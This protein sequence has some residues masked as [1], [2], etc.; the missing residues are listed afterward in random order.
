M[1]FLHKLNNKKA[2]KVKACAIESR[3]IHIHTEGH[4]KRM[5]NSVRK[6]SE[7]CLW[8]SKFYIF[9]HTVGFISLSELAESGYCKQ[10]KN[11]KL[12]GSCI[13]KPFCRKSKVPQTNHLQQVKSW[14]IH[15]VFVLYLEKSQKVSHLKWL[16]ENVLIY[17]E[18]VYLSTKWL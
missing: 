2:V 4:T 16:H 11:G 8:N 15:Q 1:F 9:E 13:N 10:T 5:T 18:P 3:S 7:V 6:K 17:Q 14:S 12:I